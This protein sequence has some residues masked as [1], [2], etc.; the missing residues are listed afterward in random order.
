MSRGEVMEQIAWLVGKEPP[1]LLVDDVH[2]RAEGNP[3][4][5]EQ[6]VAAA[7]TDSPE[8]MLRPPGALPERLAELLAARAGGC[9]DDAQAVL[10]GLAVAGRPL[11]EAQL[12]QVTG[13]SLDAVRGA[14]ENWPRAT[15]LP[16]A[17]RR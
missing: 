3:F 15:C 13:L 9:G 2:A 6:L 4:F 1:L 5:T 10:A 11:G 7:M 12:S 14:C 8:G 17:R 16:P